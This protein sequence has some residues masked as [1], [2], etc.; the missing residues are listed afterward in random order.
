M[1]SLAW[2]TREDDLPINRP[3]LLELI[4]VRVLKAFYVRGKLISIGEI[5][6][7]ERHLA[8]SLQALHKVEILK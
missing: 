4:P 8:T 2:H 5:I 3:E 7:I 1:N 6:K